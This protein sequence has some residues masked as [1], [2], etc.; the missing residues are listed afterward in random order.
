MFSQV[1]ASLSTLRLARLPM[2]NFTVL[3]PFIHFYPVHAYFTPFIPM[4]TPSYPRSSRL[5]M[6]TL[7]YPHF[8]PFTHALPQVIHQCPLL[9]RLRMFYPV[10]SH[11]F[12]E[13]ST[14]LTVLCLP[15][16]THVLICLP[17]MLTPVH[18]RSY[19]LFTHVYS[20]FIHVL[21]RLPMFTPC[22]TRLTLFTHVHPN[23]S[24][25]HPVYSRLAQVFVPMQGYKSLSSCRL[26]F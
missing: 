11:V 6:S 15:Q 13:S 24:T 14:F 9:S 17:S 23:L 26:L 22:Y 20:F 2:F 3:P 16:F 8:T 18:P 4:F 25:F 19:W 21:P 12:P 1:Y 7:V 5:P 10:Y